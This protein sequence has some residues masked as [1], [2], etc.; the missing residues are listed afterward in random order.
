MEDLSTRFANLLDKT[1]TLLVKYA[2]VRDEAGRLRGELDA[3]RRQNEEREARIRE[4]DEKVTI[5]KT[6]KEMGNDEEDRAAIRQK[7]NEYIREIDR[8][9]ALLNA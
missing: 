5:L 9:I 7:V 4:L 8:C 6:A 1:E 2:K 3:L